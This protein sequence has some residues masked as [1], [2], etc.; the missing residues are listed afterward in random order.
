MGCEL[1]FT[2]LQQNFELQQITAWQH[3]L[4]DGSQ[5]RKKK[6]NNKIATAKNTYQMLEIIREETWKVIESTIL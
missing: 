3:Q 4:P 6:K 5:K 1:F 2:T